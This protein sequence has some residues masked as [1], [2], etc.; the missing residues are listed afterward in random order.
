[1][2]KLVRSERVLLQQTLVGCVTAIVETL[3]LATP[4]VAG[5]ALRIR[6]LAR[7][8]AQGLESEDRW[9]LEFAALLSQLRAAALPKEVVE[10]YH[11]GAKLDPNELALL[12]EGTNVVNRALAGIPRLESVNRILAE[13][14]ELTQGYGVGAGDSRVSPDARLLHAIIDME[15]LESR[16]QSATQCLEVLRQRSDV[17]GQRSLDVLTDVTR[18]LEAAA[19]E[20]R[21]CHREQ[22]EAGMVLAEDLKTNDGVLLLPCGFEISNS[23]LVHIIARFKNELPVRVKVRS[24]APRSRVNVAS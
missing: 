4:A 10:R 23:A 8:A 7:K 14:G 21:S 1:M 6:D 24:T 22:L 16:G 12:A 19:E 5:R 13:L 9:R 20:A 3:S 17:Y 15:R 2:H 18:A 11:A